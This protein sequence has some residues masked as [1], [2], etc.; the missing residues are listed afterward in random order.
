VGT[1]VSEDLNPEIKTGMMSFA[2]RELMTK[3][4][5]RAMSRQD[6]SAFDSDRSDH[7]P[8][9]SYTGWPAKAA[10][11]TAEMGRFDKS[12]DML[13]RFREAFTSAIP[14]AIELTKVE[15]EDGLQA[16]VSTRAGASFAEVSGSFAEVIL[17]TFFGFRPDLEGKTA[18]WHPQKPRG[19]TGCL[20]HVRWKAG[21][22][23]IVSDSQGLHMVNEEKPQAE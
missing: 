4:W 19:F 2:D 12:L 5:M 22:Y 21:L 7:G 14:Q 8:A 3:T 11:A 17:N 16:R 9:G 20:S 1:T 6:P 15:G 10:Q 13:Q 23:T 18:L